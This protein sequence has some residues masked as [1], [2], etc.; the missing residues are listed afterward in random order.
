MSVFLLCF[1][2]V[3]VTKQMLENDFG[4]PYDVK[5]PLCTLVS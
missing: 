3:S 5:Y 2:L 4:V 1:V